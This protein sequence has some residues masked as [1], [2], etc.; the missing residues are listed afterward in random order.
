MC[1]FGDTPTRRGSCGRKSWQTGVNVS[2][3]G[4][5]ISALSSQQDDPHCTKL[6]DV[7]PPLACL[8]F[9]CPKIYNLHI[10]AF[11]QRQS[12]YTEIRLAEKVSRFSQFK[13]T[14]IIRKPLLFATTSVILE[15]QQLARSL[16]LWVKLC[17]CFL[18]YN[19]RFCLGKVK[20]QSLF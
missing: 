11:S 1:W 16:Q 6:P 7:S 2:P 12:C 10:R 9:S 18:L 8:F 13:I 3:S 4:N 5:S 17:I 19:G 20:G 15:G 14:L